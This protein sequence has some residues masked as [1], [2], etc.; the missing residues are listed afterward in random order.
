MAIQAF[1]ALERC[2]DSPS[3]IKVTFFTRKVLVE[4]FEELD[5]RVGVV[6]VVFDL[7]HDRGLAGIGPVGQSGGHRQAGPGEV[8]AQDRSLAPGSP[9]RPHGREKRES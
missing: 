3:Q 6:G 5:Q 8:M 2:A 9:G 1:M 7:E 4:L